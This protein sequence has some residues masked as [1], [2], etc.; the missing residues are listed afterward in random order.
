MFISVLLLIMLM[1]HSFFHETYVRTINE[2]EM[3]MITRR[4]KFCILWISFL[5]TCQHKTL[6]NAQNKE[7]IVN[8]TEVVPGR[9]PYQVGLINQNGSLKCGGS[10]ISPFWILTAAHCMDLYAKVEIGRHDRSDKSEIYE[11]IEIDFEVP[12]PH[13][14]RDSHYHIHDIM[15]IKLKTP[16]NYSTVQLDDG[17][18]NIEEGMNVSVMGWGVTNIVSIRPS[19]ILLEAELDISSQT[20]CHGAYEEN[21]AYIS[22]EM[23]C[24]SRPDKDSCQCD[25][26]GPLIIKGE[27]SMLDIQIGIVS[28]G[29]KCADPDYPGVYTRVSEYGNFIDSTMSC[30]WED[31]SKAYDC[32]EARCENGFYI[33]TKDDD[34]FPAEDDLFCTEKDYPPGMFDYSNCKAE[35]PCWV[36]DGHCDYGEYNT[37]ECNFDG[38]DCCS[39]TCLSSDY[40]CQEN[41]FDDCKVSFAESNTEEV[42]VL[43]ANLNK[44]ITKMSNLILFSSC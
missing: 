15:L 25:S 44:W 38:G 5:S 40:D 42:F 13:Y 43:F 33:C 30:I 29:Y 2:E 37:P 24:A 26:G 1:N 39:S 14:S 31:E 10:L 21:G 35:Y 28:F 4:I 32:C 23:I 19:N 36:G 3:K 7:M 17:S 6:V 20:E 11:K 27:D 18:L 41:I 16:S 9:Y 34:C 12:H 22:N 8:G